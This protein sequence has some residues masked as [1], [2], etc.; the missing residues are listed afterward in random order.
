[1]TRPLFSSR[2]GSSFV[3][4]MCFL[5]LSVTGIALL[6]AHVRSSV[7]TIERLPVVY[8]GK[9]IFNTATARAVT[10]LET[11][12]TSVPVDGDQC[13]VSTAAPYAILKF[14]TA[15]A[16][17]WQVQITTQA[18]WSGCRCARDFR[19]QLCR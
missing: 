11:K 10:L 18:A 9:N 13:T 1:M 2:T 12:S 7:K 6:A 8:D 17:K 14:N 19:T 16:S 3:V 15:G 4:A 5:M